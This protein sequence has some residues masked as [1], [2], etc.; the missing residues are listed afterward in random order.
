MPQKQ[1]MRNFISKLQEL[2]DKQDVLAQVIS[3]L[4][5]ELKIDS[6]GIRLKEKFEFPYYASDGFAKS[7]IDKENF[8]CKRANNGTHICDEETDEPCLECLC[9]TVIAGGDKDL[10]DTTT[11]GSFW[12]NSL[13]LYVE[14][15]SCERRNDMRG[16]CYDYKYESMALVPIPFGKN[17]LGL[18]QL[19]D[20]KADIYNVDL[21]HA[22][23]DF[24]YLL[25]TILGNLDMR[26]A[27]FNEKK[28]ILA[29]NVNEI[30]NEF[31]TF[32]TSILEKS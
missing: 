27:Q 19:N 7:F 22:I 32:T 17:N 28:I 16:V 29:K 30:I 21:I 10:P 5:S 12:C 13:S 23:E 26:S 4:K 15:L 25:G 1:K 31:K 11:F 9:G 3:F 6:V 8:I 24:S 20:F 18:L 2:T 14:G